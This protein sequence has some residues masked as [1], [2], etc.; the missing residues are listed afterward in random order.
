MASCFYEKAADETNYIYFD[1]Y[2]V[3]DL[4]MPGVFPHYH[5]SIEF[6]FMIEGESC[7]HINTK[8]KTVTAGEITFARCFEPHYYMPQKGAVYFVVLIS[9]EYLG[10]YNDFSKETFP[11]FMEGGKHFAEISEFLKAAYTVWDKGNDA[12]KKG[13]ASFL[14]GLMKKFYPTEPTKNTKATQAF[15]E[16]LKYIGEHFKEEITLE[17]LGSRF[18][19]AKNYLSGQFNKFTGMNLRE[20]INRRRLNEYYKLK[21]EQPQAPVCRIAEEA[22]FN[23]LNTFYRVMHSYE[24]NLNI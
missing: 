1:K 21:Q 12:I 15:I 5:D 20:Y 14:L 18:G 22:G 19:Y 24:N 23:S 17:S 10:G 2:C 8:E 6:V 9:S 11:S 7:I 13:F 4:W 3:T 16:I